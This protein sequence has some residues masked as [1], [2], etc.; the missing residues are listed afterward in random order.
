[1]K[2]MYEI[3]DKLSDTRIK[4]IASQI[5]T[6]KDVLF[7]SDNKIIIDLVFLQSGKEE[8]KEKEMKEG[9]ASIIVLFV[10]ENFRRDGFLKRNNKGEYRDTTIGRKLRKMLK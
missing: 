7:K 10:L 3:I 5:D 2:E 6:E 8:I 9:I 4:R 1:M